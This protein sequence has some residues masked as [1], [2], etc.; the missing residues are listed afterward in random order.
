MTTQMTYPEIRSLSK[1]RNLYF[2]LVVF[3]KYVKICHETP[4]DIKIHGKVKITSYDCHG[5]NTVIL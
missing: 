3:T 1:E 4:T 2:Q 5:K